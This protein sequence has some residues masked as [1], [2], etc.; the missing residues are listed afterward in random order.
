MIGSM[1]D[2]MEKKPA[3]EKTGK[4]TIQVMVSPGT[5][6]RIDDLIESGKFPSISD[7]GNTLE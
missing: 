4:I 2:N 5:K 6:E 1:L 7:F 3:A